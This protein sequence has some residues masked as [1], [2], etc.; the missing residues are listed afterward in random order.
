MYSGGVFRKILGKKS[1]EILHKYHK[2]IL[3]KIPVKNSKANLL[4]ILGEI[5][6]WESA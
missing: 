1:K 2:R 3:K 4:G 5:Y 6:I